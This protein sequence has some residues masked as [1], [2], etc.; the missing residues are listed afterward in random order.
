MLTARRFVAVARPWETGALLL[1]IVATVFASVALAQTDASRSA[2]VVQPGQTESASDPHHEVERGVARADP[3]ERGEAIGRGLTAAKLSAAAATLALLAFGVHLRRRG[4]ADAWRRTR[5][6]ALV[7]LA[8][9]AFAASYNFFTWR[10]ADGIHTHEFFHYYLGA[11]YF[12]EVGYYDLYECAVA[13]VTE[14]RPEA[15][16][17]AHEIRD[18][19]NIERRRRIV[20]ETRLAGC[21]ERF[22]TERWAAFRSDAMYLQSRL[23]PERFERILVDQGLNASPVWLLAGRTFAE[24]V[25]AEPD[26]LRRYARLD[27]LL[28]AAGFGAVGWAFGLE[29]LCLAV[30]AWASN[31]LTRYEWIGDAPLR[32]AWFA[33]CLIGLSLLRRRHHGAAAVFLATSALLRVFPLFYAVGY[34]ARQLRRWLTDR[35][36]DPR[37][38]RFVGFGTATGVLLI[39]L[40]IPVAGRG[41]GVVGEFADNMSSYATL[42][43]LNSMGLRALLTHDPD[44]PAPRLV[45]GAL[46][47]LEAD[48]MA[49]NRRTFSSRRP[50]YWAGVAVLLVM[51][52]RALV[53][54]EDWEAACLG[55]VLVLTFTQAASYYMTCTVGAA[56]LGTRRP[57]I[58]MAMM[59]ALVAWGTIIL[60]FESTANAYALASAV[61]L[62]LAV[63]TMIEIRRPVAD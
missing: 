56:L 10:H 7:A 9:F 51:F 27:L 19:R 57:R 59:A 12:P 18:L 8:L 24:W 45:D 47:Y 54:A 21:R 46:V 31:P 63:Y 16:R 41:V 15:A 42:K 49:K 61:A 38:V 28:L 33:T 55:F 6:V 36:V 52:W 30:I 40:A 62:L 53:R 17:R 60:A 22:G 25:P 14:G 23:P 34:A 29:G 44:P 39:A 43:G 4:R 5:R 11:K 37:F 58:A 32:Q 35:I 20:P 1:V 13:A 26:A 3:I 50:L 48:R 2:R